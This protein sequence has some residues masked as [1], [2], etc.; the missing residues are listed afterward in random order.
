MSRPM[1]GHALKLLTVVAMLSCGRDV[2]PTSSLERIATPMARYEDLCWPP[3]TATC[4][5]R[6]LTTNEGNR[7]TLGTMAINDQGGYMC[8]QLKE[9]ALTDMGNGSVKMWTVGD[10]SYD[11]AN[12]D[13]DR[14]NSPGVTH[15]T[16]NAFRD[17]STLMKTLIHEAAHA[18]GVWDDEDAYTLEEQCL[19]NIDYWSP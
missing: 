14:H 7:A 18:V 8:Q 15:L 16:T 2:A 1:H 19:G 12:Y 6:P 11:P 4:Q 3:G 9:Q 17:N 10:A 5:D 13:G